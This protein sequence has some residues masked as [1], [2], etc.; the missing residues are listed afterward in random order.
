[1]PNALSR[2]DLLAQLRTQGAVMG[3]KVHDDGDQELVGE[4]ESIVSRWWLGGRKVIYR[5]SCRPTED[6]HILHFREAVTE[7]SWGLPPPTMTVEKSTV[8]GWK[9]SGE[10]SDMAVGGGGT[11]DYARVRE[12]VERTVTAAGW[13]F[14]F[15]GGRKP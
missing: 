7:R 5:I 3:L 10:R 13:Q 9:R 1:M 12:A 6:D 8:S 11:L 4:A 15:E 2:R 14:Q